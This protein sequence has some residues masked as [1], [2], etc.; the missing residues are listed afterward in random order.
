M[1]FEHCS[2]RYFFLL[3]E[4]NR[5]MTSGRNINKI[6]LSF[7][8]KRPLLTQFVLFLHRLLT[9][10]RSANSPKDTLCN[11]VGDNFVTMQSKFWIQHLCLLIIFPLLQ[12]MQYF[13][14]FR[15]IFYGRDAHMDKFLS[16][17]SSSQTSSH[18]PSHFYIHVH[19]FGYYAS[20]WL[21]VSNVC[22]IFKHK[23]M[24]EFCKW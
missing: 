23:T 15:T 10:K 24:N 21:Q 6:S 19:F 13:E 1:D 12:T 7:Y 18:W 3:S 11:C 2:I 16:P 4:S 20:S 8:W 22:V 5:K 17:R 14:T 9:L